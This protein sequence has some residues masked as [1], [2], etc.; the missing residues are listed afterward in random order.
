MWGRV[1]KI[2]ADWGSGLTFGD[3]VMRIA[4]ALLPVGG[5]GY[6]TWAAAGTGWLHAWG[7]IGVASAGVLGFAVMALTLTAGYAF[8]GYGRKRSAEA[9][10]RNYLATPNTAINPLAG[11]FTGQKLPCL[12]FELMF[13]RSI[14][15]RVEKYS[16]TA[17]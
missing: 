12:I 2:V 17:S 8:V 1:K 14:F 11:R 9:A 6:M 4:G 13:R 7:P 3:Y 5:G 16:R 10:F 15:H